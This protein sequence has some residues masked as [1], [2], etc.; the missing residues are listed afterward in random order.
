LSATGVI[1]RRWPHLGAAVCGRAAPFFD[2]VI[3][4]FEKRRRKTITTL[5]LHLQSGCDVS[6]KLTVYFFN[7]ASKKTAA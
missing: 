3:D 2:A 5:V 6:H 1:T 7:G 4:G